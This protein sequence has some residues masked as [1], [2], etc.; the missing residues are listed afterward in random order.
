MT[1]PPKKTLK[2]AKAKVPPRPKV[3]WTKPVTLTLKAQ[4]EEP[5]RRVT[6]ADLERAAVAAA[7]SFRATLEN[8]TPAYEVVRLDATIEYAYLQSEKTF[9]A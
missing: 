9:D 7:A 4:F 1:Q 8:Q 3:P 2:R 5:G 6:H